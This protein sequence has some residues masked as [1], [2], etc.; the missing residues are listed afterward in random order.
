MLVKRSIQPPLRTF[1]KLRG[2]VSNERY[3]REEAPMRGL[4]EGGRELERDTSGRGRRV[5]PDRRIAGDY[6][7]GRRHSR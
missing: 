2:C 5:D 1:C 3:T 4:S 6:E 7:R